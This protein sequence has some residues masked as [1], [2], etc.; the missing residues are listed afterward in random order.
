MVV[1]MDNQPGD[2]GALAKV[3]MKRLVQLN[4]RLSYMSEML[5]LERGEVTRLA[6]SV[7][8]YLTC[9]AEA[10]ER[11]AALVTENRGLRDAG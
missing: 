4:G 1:P 3:L 8:R 5:H 6:A 11:I 9:L 10:E 7:D 2:K